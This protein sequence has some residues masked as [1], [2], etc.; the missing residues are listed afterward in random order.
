MALAL[1]MDLLLVRLA[2]T[3]VPICIALHFN[4]EDIIVVSGQEP[5]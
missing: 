3:K 1:Y 5:P 2:D 4:S